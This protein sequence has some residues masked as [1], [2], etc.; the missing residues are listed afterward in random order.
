MAISKY[1][2]GESSNLA[3]GQMGFTL[4]P[5]DD[6][7]VATSDNIKEGNFVAIKALN[8]DI[9]VTTENSLGDI[10]T[11]QTIPQSE[12][13]YGIFTK[14]TRTDTTSSNVCLAYRG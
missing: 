10:L 11:G 1:T 9:S 13:L 14:I 7:D 12:I 6:E 4:I 8:G 2:V 5:Y 3:L